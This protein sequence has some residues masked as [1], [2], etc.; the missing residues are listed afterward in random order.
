MGLIWRQSHE[1]K[2]KKYPEVTTV[3]EMRYKNKFLILIALSFALKVDSS[4]TNMHSRTHGHAHTHTHIHTHHT[5]HTRDS[6]ESGCTTILTHVKV[7]NQKSGSKTSV[8]VCSRVVM[9]QCS[10]SL[11]V[12]NT[13]VYD[14]HVHLYRNC[15]LVDIDVAQF[16]Q[17]LVNQTIACYSKWIMGKFHARQ[18]EHS[19]RYW[20]EFIQTHWELY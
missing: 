5:Q 20:A 3:C 15:R 19:D 8:E 12:S 16:W 6:W 4:H 13:C 17:S 1:R 9:W 7:H 10:W 14:D 11:W 2:P 18:K